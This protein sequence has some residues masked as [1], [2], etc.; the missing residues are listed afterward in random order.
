MPQ[1]VGVGRKNYEIFYA[2]VLRIAVHV[3]HG[4]EARQ[5][6]PEPGFAQQSMLGNQLSL[7][8][9]R[10]QRRVHVPVIANQPSP[11][12][13]AGVLRSRLWSGSLRSQTEPFAHSPDMR[14]AASKQFSG[15]VLRQQLDFNQTFHMGGVE[16]KGYRH[17]LILLVVTATRS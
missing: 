10:V 16:V 7:R 9:V 17:C 5:I 11:T 12:L 13:P 3:M 15:F 6:A 2:V 4:F 1:V 14:A 8:P